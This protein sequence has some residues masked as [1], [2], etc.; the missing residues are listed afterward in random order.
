MHAHHHHRAPGPELPAILVDGVEIPAAEIAAE[1]QHHP[2]DSAQSAWH[3]AAEALVLRRLLLDE[4]ARRG[5]ATTPGE[6][7]TAEEAAIRGLLDTAITVPEADEATC[8]RWYEAN[9]ARFRS[10]EAW[11][12]A[13]VLI[14]AD[15]AD[16]PARTA[17]RARAAALLAEVQAAPERL[18]ELAARHSDCPSREAGGD[19]GP[20]TT[21]STVPEFEAALR[22]LQPGETAPEPVETRYGFHVV[23]VLARAP[24]REIPFDTAR[25]RV[26][27]YLREA[28]YRRAVRQYLSVLAGRAEIAG[29]ILSAAAEGP[30][31]Q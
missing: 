12:A 22:A 16:A 29:I 26:A 23:R 11:Q 25:D 7:E 9:R 4:A 27:E 10:P 21:G 30:L 14:A 8:R 28:S 24:G 31:V 1:M 20:V 15:P 17:A 3:Q 6:G 19:L 18:A 5:H 13:H 2:A